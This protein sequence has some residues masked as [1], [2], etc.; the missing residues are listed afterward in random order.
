MFQ[1]LLTTII[2]FYCIFFSLSVHQA[3]LGMLKETEDIAG[4][5]EVIS[6]ELQSKVYK[7]LQN[8]HNEAKQERKKVVRRISE[9]LFIF[10]WQCVYTHKNHQL[11]TML[12]RT[13]CNNI[14]LHLLFTVVNNIV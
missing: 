7:E 14:V 6:E 11:V 8:L 3:F 2:H 12:I 9:T 5:H 13:A 10:I 1:D 4:Q